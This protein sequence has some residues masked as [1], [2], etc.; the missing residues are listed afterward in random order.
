MTRL[1]PNSLAE[2]LL[3]FLRQGITAERLAFSIALGGALSCFPIVGTT[4]ILCTIVALTFRLNLPAIQVGNYLAF[5][6][7]LA[8]FVP[9]L[10]LGERLTRAQHMPLAPDQLLAMAKASPDET[11]RVLLAGQWHSILG[12]LIVAPAILPLFYLP[13]RP[14]MKLLLARAATTPVPTPATITIQR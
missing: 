13:L 5:P 9:F 4:T 8:L 10:R 1:A 11:L 7:Q 6:L 12:W 3:D 2:R 14:L